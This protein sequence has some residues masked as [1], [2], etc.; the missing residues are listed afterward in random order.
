MHEQL[1]HT[2]DAIVAEIQEIQREAREHG[3]KKRP[4]WP[5]LIFATPKGWTGP[6][7]VDGLQ[8]EGT[9]RAHQI[10]LSHFAGHPE[11]IKMLENWMRSY[12]PEE[13]IDDKGTLLPELRALAP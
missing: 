5:L 4:R 7:T 6:K 9:F 12:R 11:H 8:I 13:L 3:F 10:P 1:A 2:F